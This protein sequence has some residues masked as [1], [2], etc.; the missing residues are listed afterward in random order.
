MGECRAGRC[1]AGLAAV[2]QR[3]PDW[4]ELEAE[5]GRAREEA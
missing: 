4:A 1:H 3:E 2:A 5:G